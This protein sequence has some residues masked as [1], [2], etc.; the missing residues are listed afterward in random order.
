MT[1]FDPTSPSS[2][3]PGPPVDPDVLDAI[4]RHFHLGH[5]ER[6]TAL[7]H[8][9]GPSDKFLIVAAN[10]P[11]VL[12]RRR[13][14]S[15][16]PQRLT[17]I[18]EMQIALAEHDFPVAEL[19]GTFPANRSMVARGGFT[20]E[21]THVVRAEPFDQTLPAAEDAGRTLARLHIELVEFE[22][23]LAAV[24]KN[25]RYHGLDL[26]PGIAPL[27]R[28]LAERDAGPSR[29]D[30]E[31]AA[32][33]LIA[34]Y[35]SARDAVIQLGWPNWP[36][37]VV[38][39]DWHPGNLLFKEH[40]VAAVF[41]LDTVRVEPR[42]ADVAYG[43]LQ[44]SMVRR[45]PDPRHWPAPPDLDRLAAFIHGYDSFHEGFLLSQAEVRALPRLMIEALVAE[46][47]GPLLREGK[48]GPFSGAAFLMMIERK[49]NWLAANADAVIHAVGV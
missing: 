29:Q 16:S 20:Y 42:V 47:V 38:H 25:S 11:Y 14:D 2:S 9:A 12:K 17:L 49:V 18:H 23:R 34:R 31:P 48:F 7:A 6:L 28:S 4:E 43:A 10:E 33:A 39:A 27:V 32:S 24:G 44:F 37:M 40:R 15:I 30:L 45:G 21:I 1:Q 46:S 8:G 22:E 3:D 5:I 36:A 19:V 41:D 26:R 35:E 13:A